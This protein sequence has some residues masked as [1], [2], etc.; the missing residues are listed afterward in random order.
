MSLE[1]NFKFEVRPMQ[2][3]Q[4]DTGAGGTNV[5]IRGG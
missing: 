1:Q 4:T 2:D 5:L 3:F